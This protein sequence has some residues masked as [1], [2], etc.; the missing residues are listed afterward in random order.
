MPKKKPIKK[1]YTRPIDHNETM[2][3]IIA[4]R[5]H[6]E[7]PFPKRRFTPK[8][9]KQNKNL[10]PG[11][12]EN[13]LNGWEFCRGKERFHKF[14][15]GGMTRYGSSSGTSVDT[16]LNNGV[17]TQFVNSTTNFYNGPN[18]VKQYK[19]ILNICNQYAKYTF[20]CIF[21]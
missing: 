7:L 5:R 6:M 11:E 19:N 1:G 9:K 20:P 15:S 18:G 3:T 16:I 14:N 2:K 13:T 21:P 17:L 8:P 10:G 12:Y 4:R